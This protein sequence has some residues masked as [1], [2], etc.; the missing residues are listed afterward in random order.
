MAWFVCHPPIYPKFLGML[1]ATW[2]TAN[3]DEEI[4]TGSLPWGGEQTNGGEGRG[5]LMWT[6]RDCD[7]ILR[8]PFS[9][10]GVIL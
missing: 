4:L 8:C 6:G 3:V 10:R 9:R 2:P 7:A 1:S 5:K